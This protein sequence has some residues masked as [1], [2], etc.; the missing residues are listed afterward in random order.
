MNS[1]W[2]CW[3]H[4]ACGGTVSMCIFDGGGGGS[5]DNDDDEIITII[6]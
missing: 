3:R 6:I 5:E 4:G 2:V 1:G